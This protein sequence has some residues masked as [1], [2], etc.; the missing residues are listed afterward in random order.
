VAPYTWSG[1]LASITCDP[2]PTLT[3]HDD[4]AQNNVTDYKFLQDLAERWG[5]RA[6]VEYNDGKSKFYWVSTKTLLEGEPLA[7]LRYCRGTDRLIEFKYQSI[8]ARADR[9]MVASAVDPVSGKVKTVKSAAPAADSSG[10]GKIVTP[11]P[12]AKV[13]GL[14]S[15]PQS[16]E[17]ET[18]FDP[19][20]LLGLSGNGRAAGN[21]NLRAKGRVTLV[22]LA[23][24]AEG[25]WYISK[26]THIWKNTSTPEV[27]GS[28][29]ET[30]FE[31]TR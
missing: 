22:G 10:G 3:K 26:A 15:D 18:V 19:T 1:D 2:N 9:Q 13:V 14:P 11:P 28:S 31:A 5:G 27:P 25:D 29:Y 12:P 24:W 30:L 7:K 17:R 20:R 8:A 21:I 6:F 16:A 4:L 23:P